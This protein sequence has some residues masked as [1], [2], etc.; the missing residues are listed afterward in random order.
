MQLTSLSLALT[1]AGLGGF[2]SDAEPIYPPGNPEMVAQLA[3]AN[4]YETPT[5]Q[6]QALFDASGITEEPSNG[7]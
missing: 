5:E 3:T 6:V 4:G 2:P 1:R 7:E